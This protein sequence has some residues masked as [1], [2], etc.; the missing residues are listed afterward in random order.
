MQE[1]SWAL[2]GTARANIAAAIAHLLHE[3]PPEVPSV[4]GALEPKPP[5]PPVPEPDLEALAKAAAAA[6]RKKKPKP[7]QPPPDGKDAG[8]GA[9]KGKKPPSAGKKGAAEGAPLE[10]PPLPL[11]NGELEL[12][13]FPP[14]TPADGSGTPIP[15]GT[16][17]ALVPP[18]SASLG[19]PNAA[20][21]SAAAP[22]AAAAAAPPAPPV[23]VAAVDLRTQLVKLN[24]LEPLLGMLRNGTPEERL[25][26]AVRLLASRL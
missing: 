5:P 4:V 16:A 9:P 6:P 12:H 20:A 21:G 17:D 2:L 15:P 10:G 26:A 22:A 18:G 1:P 8:K 19:A 13:A 14:A 11:P 3:R 7:P 25:H 23:H 24:V